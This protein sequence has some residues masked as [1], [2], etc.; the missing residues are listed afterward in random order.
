MILFLFWVRLL[1]DYLDAVIKGT[2][3]CL[4]KKKQL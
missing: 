1:K 2:A 3:K 4:N